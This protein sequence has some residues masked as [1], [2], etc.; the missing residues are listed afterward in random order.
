MKESHL[1]RF[2][3][4]DLE[5]TGMTG[6]D[7]RII[8]IGIILIDERE[9]GMLFVDSYDSLVRPDQKVPTKVLELTGIDERELVSAPRFVDIAAH[10]ELLTR[11]RI[12][13]AHGVQGD[14]ELLRAHFDSIGID[15]RRK[16]LCTA[17]LARENDPSIGAY[18]LLSLCRLYDIDFTHHHRA[19]SDAIACAKLFTRIYQPKKRAYSALETLI[20]RT[21]TQF[22]KINLKELIVAKDEAVI[23]FLY[24]DQKIICIEAFP[25]ALDSLLKGLL[26][27]KSGQFDKISLKT[28]PHYLLAIVDSTL[29]KRRFKPKLNFYERV[30]LVVGEGGYPQEDFELELETKGAMSASVIFRAGKLFSVM[31]NGSERR[32]KETKELRKAILRYLLSSKSAKVR[33]YRLK[34]IKRVT[35]N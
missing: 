27:F 15:F 9:E 1:K 33:S 16:V 29:L 6:A 23:L 13:V 12:V 17:L 5:A 2:A 26:K 8:E 18:D 25:P 24:K 14:F 32:M 28:Y 10:V 31:R 4:I 22:P 35:I 30:D 19:L 3:I 34:S 11:D 20:Y 7:D 21:L